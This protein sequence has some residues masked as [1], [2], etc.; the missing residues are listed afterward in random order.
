[1]LKS[2]FSKII[3]FALVSVIV[4]G[5]SSCSIF[6][7]VRQI[8]KDSGRNRDSQTSQSSANPKPVKGNTIKGDEPDAEL[9]RRILSDFQNEDFEAIDRQADAARRGKERL[10]GGYWKLKIIYA[11]LSKIYTDGFVTEQMWTEHLDKVKRWKQKSPT[12][13]T[14]RVALAESYTGY[15]WFARR[16]GFSNTVAPEDSAKTRDRLDLAYNELVEA[17][18]LADKCPQWYNTMLFL[19]MAQDWE[20][21]DYDRLFDEATSFEPNYYYYY[22]SKAENS[23]PRWGGRKGDWEKF[24]VELENLDSKEKNIVYFLYVG[25]E[26]C[27]NY[28][29]WTDRESISWERAKLGYKELEATYGT[30]KQRLNQYAFLAS[31][32]EDMPEAYHAFKQIGDDRDEDVFSEARFYEIK[33]WAVARYEAENP[34]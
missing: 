27:Y 32:N 20:A 4:A 25:N 2:A 6:G 30:D 7:V 33:T 13:V 8:A 22:F 14:A 21:E 3:V 5:Q 18:K 10:P 28:N 1:M 26:I 11:P 16:S 31:V 17:Q 23:L 15:A 19:A 29:E 24:A 34:K 9:E 12:S